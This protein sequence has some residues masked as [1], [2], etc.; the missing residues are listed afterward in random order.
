M[1]AHILYENIDKKIAPYS[2][3]FMTMILEESINYKGLIISDDLSMLALKGSII[4]RAKNCF[5]GGCDVVLYCS[6]NID[7][8]IEIYNHCE[9]I[10][11]KKFEYFEK[12]MKKY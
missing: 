1:V 4:E 10:S 9:E 2:N 3:K 6:G 7:E 5:E 12:C 11:K 8:M